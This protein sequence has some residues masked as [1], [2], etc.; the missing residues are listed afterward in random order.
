MKFKFLGTPECP[1]TI[2]L[3]DVVF[4]KGKAVEVSDDL[5][6]KLARLEYFAEVKA[7][8]PKNAKDGQ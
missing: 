2:T 7:G 5:A 6:L 4:D 3:R 8:R 1:D